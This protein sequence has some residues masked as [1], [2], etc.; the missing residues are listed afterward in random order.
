MVTIPKPVGVAGVVVYL[1]IVVAL[2]AFAPTLGGAAL[3]AVLTLV[4]IVVFAY[5]AYVLGGRLNDR[6]RHGKP[7]LRREGDG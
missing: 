6:L 7:M 1:V 5:L 2:L 4:A 3:G